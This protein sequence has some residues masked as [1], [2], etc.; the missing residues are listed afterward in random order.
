MNDLKITT[1]HKWKPFKYRQEVPKK[2]IKSQ[3]DYQ[4][5]EECIDDFFCYK[6]NWYHIDQFMTVGDNSPLK[7]WDG[8]SSDSFFSGIVIKL[9]PDGEEYM[10]GWYCS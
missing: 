8:Y 3:F 10:V 4:D 1:D 6:G 2:V 7:G 9:K 5:G